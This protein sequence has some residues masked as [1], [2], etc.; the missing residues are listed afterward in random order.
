M[1]DKD[2][3]VV[4]GVNQ[5]TSLTPLNG[6]AEDATAFAQWLTTN[7]GVPPGNVVTVPNNGNPLLPLQDTIDDELGKILAN[8]PGQRRLYFFFAGHGVAKSTMANG[9]CLPKWSQLYSN[10]ALSI[11]KYL[12]Q[13]GN[14]GFFQE[15]VFFIDGCSDFVLNIDPQGPLFNYPPMDE[16]PE[17][18]LAF[19]AKF[20]NQAQEA[21]MTVNGNMTIRGLFSMA[22]MEGLNGL[23][24]NE[25]GEV[26]T[27]SL[28]Q[29]LII[30]MAA[31]AKQYSID[32]VPRFSAPNMGNP[33]VLARYPERPLPFRLNVTL[34]APGQ[35]QLFDG[36]MKVIRSGDQSTSPWSLDVTFGKYAIQK[37]NDERKTFS[38]DNTSNPIN[39]VV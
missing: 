19:A 10:A 8:G 24:M 28:R 27:E 18:F 9:I 13:I 25:D 30:R 6:P 35:Y 23:A 4:I 14:P 1:N 11:P 17:S 2:Y 22:L 37:D 38:I 34:S 20:N 31:L 39:Y 36:Q 3:A 12:E 33:L 21:M 29:Y 15:L 7:G 26:T 32:Q 5:Y 16:V